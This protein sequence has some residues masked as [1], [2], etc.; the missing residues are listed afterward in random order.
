MSNHVNRCRNCEHIESIHGNDGGGSHC[1]RGWL[2]SYQNGKM[3]PHCYC[4]GYEPLDNLKYL[5]YMSKRKDNES[6]A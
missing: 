6:L 5:E 1:R 4:K 2:V 3:L